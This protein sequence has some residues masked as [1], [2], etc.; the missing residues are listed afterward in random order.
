MLQNT[1]TY[2]MCLYSLRHRLVTKVLSSTEPDALD[3]SL[4]S[5]T[6]LMLANSSTMEWK[7]TFAANHS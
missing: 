1:S 3:K 7:V 2:S 4:I 5:E 6:S